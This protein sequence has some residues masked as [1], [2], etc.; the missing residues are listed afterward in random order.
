MK[1]IFSLF[2]CMMLLL[3]LFVSC[4]HGGNTVN[5]QVTDALTRVETEPNT[6]EGTTDTGTTPVTPPEPTY[7]IRDFGKTLISNWDF[8]GATEEERLLDKSA[9]GNSVETITMT[10]SGVSVIDGKLTVTDGIGNYASIDCEADSDLCDLTNKTIVYKARISDDESNGYSGRVA[11]IFSKKSSLT[12]YFSS[13]VE[14]RCSNLIYRLNENGSNQSVQSRSKTAVNEWRV[15]AVS[16]AVDPT[17]KAGKITVYKSLVETPVSYKDFEEVITV[18]LENLPN[19]F[20]QGEDAIYLGKRYNH[21]ED[22]RTMISEFAAIQVYDMVLNVAEIATINF[23]LDSATLIA[24]LNALIE[25]ANGIEK[26]LNSENQWAAFTATL[27]DA[28]ALTSD[29]APISI[30]NSIL[31]L[32]K[33]IELV[34]IELAPNS[35]GELALIAYNNSDITAPIQVGFHSYPGFYDID[36]DGDMDLIMSG[37]SRSY[38]G[39]LGGGLFLNRNLTGNVGTTLLGPT[40]HL[41]SNAGNP[42]YSYKKDGSSVFVDKNGVMYTKLTARGFEDGVS[43]DALTTQFKLYDMDGDGLS[44]AV[45]VYNSINGEN[46]YDENGNSLQTRTS[47]IRWI[48]NTGTEENPVFTGT[49][50]TV[51]NKQA[52]IFAV[53]DEG[54]YTFFRTFSMFDWDGDGDL[55][56]IAGGWQ[57]EFYYYQ[58][59]GNAQNPVFDNEGV[60]IETV[61]G[62]LELDCC[63]YNV[64]NYDWDGDGKDDLIIGSE[65]G[66]ALYLRFTGRFSEATGAPIFEDGKYLEQEAQYLAINALSRPTAC[67]WDGDGDIDLIV[68]DNSGLLWYYENLTGGADPKWAMPVKM[69]DE[70]GNVLL[71]KAGYNGSLQGTME[72]EWGYTV[73]CAADW[74]GDG[75]I[76]II[77]NSV[78]GR[79]LWF[80][81]IGTPTNGQL[82]QPK[83]IEVEWENGN[84]Y[85]TWQWWKPEGNELVAQHRSTPYAIDLNSD[86]LCDLVIIDH[87]GYLSFFERYEENGTLKL[88]QGTR[89]F[90]T[91]SGTPLQLTSKTEGQSGR[92]KFVL[93]DWDGDGLIDLLVGSNNFEFYKTV[94]IQDGNYYLQ[95]QGDLTTASIAGHNHGFTVVDWNGDG[96]P[97]IVTGTESGFFYYFENKT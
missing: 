93:T 69:T 73:P 48:K 53:T 33:Q 66:T 85:P 25:Q 88:K 71:I 47:T 6:S 4:N 74:D 2:L 87:E 54:Q 45:F 84:L 26:G 80:E 91:E 95:S 64:V 81:N 3:P 34:T 14:K 86:G 60:K 50:K 44:D 90:L 12:M 20:M 56:L 67:D 79:I 17:T 63:R 70:N 8:K 40:E 1:K 27:N 18:E 19:D 31:E 96:T 51:R 46:T 92:I 22:Y 58:N 15:H 9:E 43:F 62:P 94:K 28:K 41:M 89:I 23:D 13:A 11:A 35:I 55:D 24:E 97:D 61:S 52:K 78:T 39:V 68:G 38:G 57:N 75:D 21:L 76:D 5:T 72:A 29:S 49:A 30:Q 83:A 65:S 82:T 16:I 36:G 77:V 42:L 7:E 10:G 32:K 59:Y 37:S